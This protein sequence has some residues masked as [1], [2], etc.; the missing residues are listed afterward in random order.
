MYFITFSRKMGTGGS[1]IAQ[2][3]AD[4]LGYKFHDTDAIE[5][6]AREM[7]FLDDVRKVDEKPPSFFMRFFSQKPEAHADR[8]DSVIYELASR[9]NAVFLGRGSTSCCAPLIAPSMYG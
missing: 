1:E 9:G 4:Q 3:V 5:N 2:R 8:L 6:M 7:G